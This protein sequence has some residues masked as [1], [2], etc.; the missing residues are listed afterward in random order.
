[1]S[2]V[3]QIAEAHRLQRERGYGGRRVAVEL[4]ISRELANQLLAEPN[5]A[6]DP[7]I[8]TVTRAILATVPGARATS[9][10]I[11]VTHRSTVAG[12]SAC[13]TWTARPERLAELIVAALDAA[14]G[15]AQ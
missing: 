11:T 10:M 14:E 6:E 2:T 3:D 7:R 13:E 9:T 12:H 1:M 4:G 5:P 15:V 8:Q